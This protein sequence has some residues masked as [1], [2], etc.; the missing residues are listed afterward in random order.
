MDAYD[1]LV[2]HITG[3]AIMNAYF[4]VDTFFFISGL[5]VA[6]LSLKDA[7]RLQVNRVPMMYIQRYLRYEV[8]LVTVSQVVLT[9]GVSI[10]C[11]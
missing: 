8:F 2:S 3:Q 5:L 10:L 11:T 4:S 9:L 6:F 7:S 1:Y